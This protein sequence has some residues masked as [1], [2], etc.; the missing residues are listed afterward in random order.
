MQTRASRLTDV[1]TSREINEIAE[2]QPGAGNTGEGENKRARSQ[3]QPVPADNEA[4]RMS[5][6]NVGQD[7]KVKIEA[8]EGSK[9]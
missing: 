6:A 1:I 9:S 4:P 8:V 3:E 2:M 7:G 5:V